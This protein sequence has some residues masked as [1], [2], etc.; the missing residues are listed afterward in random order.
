MALRVASGAGKWAKFTASDSIGD[1]EGVATV[2]VDRLVV[3]GEIRSRSV[4]STSRPRAT[5]V[6][7]ARSVYRKFR[8]VTAL[9]T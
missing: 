4:G 9:Q 8:R 3:S 7:T 2:K 6:A 5:R 1:A